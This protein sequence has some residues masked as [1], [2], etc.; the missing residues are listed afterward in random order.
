M[1][2]TDIKAAVEKPTWSVVGYAHLFY[3]E[4]FGELLLK[5]GVGMSLIFCHFSG[6]FSSYWV[7]L[8]SLH[9]SICIL[10]YPG[11]TVSYCTEFGSW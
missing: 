3:G 4:Y 1:R 5:V 10:L 7:T 9:V 11:L 8:T 2:L 6:P